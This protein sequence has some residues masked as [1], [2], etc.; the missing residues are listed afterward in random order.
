MLDS[1]GNIAE[2]AA[3]NFF[4]ITNG[5]L[6]TPGLRNILGGITR[7]VTMEL[8]EQIGIPVEDGYYQPYD[9]YTAD[10]AFLSTTSYSILPVTRVNGATIGR[11]GRVIGPV[12]ERLLRAWHELTGV[13][14]VAQALSHL[15][16]AERAAAGGL[17]VAAR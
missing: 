16:D 1:D 5:K 7:E 6:Y 2:A 17:A 11:H 8:A 4:W 3:G 9:L 10:E 15:T 14:L 12:T 13:D